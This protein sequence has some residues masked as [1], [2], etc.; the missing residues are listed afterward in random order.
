[1]MW[2]F[3]QTSFQYHGKHYTIVTNSLRH[4]RI[5][6]ER[7]GILWI[8][9]KITHEKASIKMCHLHPVNLLMRRPRQDYNSLDAQ[10]WSCEAY[11]ASQKPSWGAW[12]KNTI[13]TAVFVG[14]ERPAL[15]TLLN[16]IRSGHID[17]VCCLQKL[18]MT[19][20]SGL[21]QSWSKYLMDTA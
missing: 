16:D 10:G 1:M 13:M 15:K 14:C 6:M 20:S 11:I 9:R 18:A 7:L 4:Y 21:C 8:K 19:R 2:Q 17:I 5:K 12:W 3:L